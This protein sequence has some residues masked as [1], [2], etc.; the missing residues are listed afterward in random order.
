MIKASDD[1]RS[2]HQTILHVM[3]LAERMLKKRRDSDDEAI[4]DDYK[5]LIYFLKIFIDKCHHG[6][7]EHFLFD[8]LCRNGVV[9]E[10]GPIGQLLNDH[11]SAK[12][13]VVSMEESL[14]SKNIE[15]FSSTF[16]NY[17][18][19]IRKHILR[20]DKVFFIADNLFPEEEQKELLEKFE[21]FEEKV[22]GHGI[23]ES[24]FSLVNKWE[25]AY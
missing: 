10:G 7:E 5:D 4:N 9:C 15:K 1:L 22:I 13:M 17:I 19:L 24:L 2:E 23:H 11:N 3:I 21:K 12:A 25:G 8:E 14:N 16:Y 20:E 18:D 6:K